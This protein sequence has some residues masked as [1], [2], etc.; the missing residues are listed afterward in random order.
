LA[1]AELLKE[2]AR[3]VRRNDYEMPSVCTPEELMG[4]EDKT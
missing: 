4:V 3:L 1:N 2:I